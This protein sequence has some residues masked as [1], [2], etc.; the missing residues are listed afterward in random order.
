MKNLKHVHTKTVLLQWVLT[1]II[2]L[3]IPFVSIIINFFIGRNIINKQIQN[4]NHVIMNHMQN[5]IDDKLQSIKNLSYLL[6]LDNNLLKL[7]E[8]S[9]QEDFLSQAQICY[10]ELNNYNYIYNDLNMIIYYPARNYVITSG[11]ANE[12]A[13]VYNAMNYSYHGDMISYEEWMSVIGA[14][15]ST[16][17][18][19]LSDYCNYNNIGKKSFVFACTSPFVNREDSDYNILVSSTADFIESDLEELDRRTFFICDRD[20]NVIQQFGTEVENIAT[21]PL[22]FPEDYTYIDL[23]EENYFCYSTASALTG[24]NYVLCT[25]SSLYLRDSI[26]MRNV[27]LISTFASLAVGIFIVLYTQ[28]R[29]YKPV[30]KLMD[31]IP[32]SIKSG[33]TDE[34][35]QIELYHGEMY[36]LNLFMQNKLDNISK[37]VRELYFYSKLK[38]VNFH[39][40]EKDVINT[41]NLDFSG[42]QF[43]I[44]SVYAD[45]HSFSNDDVMRNW[46]LLQ[47]AVQNV[48]DE[49]LAKHFDFETIQDEFFH[50]FFFALDEN[51]LAEWKL[52][53]FGYFKQLYDFFNCQFHIPLFITISPVYESFEQTTDQYTDMISSFEEYYAKKIPGVNLA[54]KHNRNVIS[55]HME[56]GEYSKNINMSI[57]QNDY[58]KACETV[59]DY[60]L[61]LKAYNFSKIIVRYNIYSLIASILMDAGDYI[62]QVTRDTIDSYLSDSFNCNTFEEYEDKMKQLLLYLCNQSDGLTDNTQGKE[63]QLVKKVKNFVDNYYSDVNLSVASVADAVNLSPNYTSKIFK[64]L[65]G[66]GLLSYINHVRINRAKELLRITNINIDEIA[67]MVGFSNTRSFRRNFQSLTGITASDYR[68][69]AK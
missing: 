41:L 36:R 29:N 12:S 15:Y 35:Q 16:S 5:A 18:Y 47:F 40:Q 26:W 44:A 54:V 28:Y 63:A 14:D 32:S 7:S 19:F 64:N 9:Y 2:I 20:G 43:V 6:L 57:F 8:I 34:F 62:S 59:H 31:F 58:Q 21:L 23:N 33:E 22:S 66:E 24:W 51:K 37:N 25:P 38:G 65:T 30:K 3:L 53:G 48:S 56:F 39:T 13:S 61:N 4:S 60:I 42:K 10:N 69:G 52:C 50:V 27:T 49:I 46:E 68:N 1:C 55:N 45:S 17:R 67:L 11:V